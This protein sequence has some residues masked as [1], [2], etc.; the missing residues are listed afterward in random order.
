M[1]KK[2][3]PGLNKLLI[4]KEDLPDTG[5]LL[6][7]G[8]SNLAYGEIYAVGAIKDRETIDKTM[9]VEGNKIYYYGTSGI[10]IELPEIGTL[11]LI[12][13]AEVLVGVRHE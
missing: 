1:T 4:K 3:Y 5:S 8:N 11:R 12:N 13:A 10:D 9:F 2:F 7:L 6:S